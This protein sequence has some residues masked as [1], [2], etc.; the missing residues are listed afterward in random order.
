MTESKARGGAIRRIV[1]VWPGLNFRVE[2][3]FVQIRE[4]PPGFE[5]FSWLRVTHWLTREALFSTFG[6]IAHA[7]E[8]AHFA[9]AA[10]A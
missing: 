8:Y 5:L 4:R 3:K 7:C 2:S 9:R 10:V 1:R 6:V